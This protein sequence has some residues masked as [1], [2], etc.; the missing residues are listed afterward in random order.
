MLDWYYPID[1][2]SVIYKRLLPN[3]WKKKTIS[4]LT[5]N[6]KLLLF[7]FILLI[8]KPDLLF[9]NFIKKHISKRSSICNTVYSSVYT[10]MTYIENIQMN[11]QG[12]KI[13]EKKLLLPTKRRG[14]QG[15]KSGFLFII[16]YVN[17]IA[18]K[19]FFMCRHCYVFR[20]IIKTLRERG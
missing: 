10:S 6:I 18:K 16:K 5:S 3:P 14:Y 11:W 9:Q 8:V 15:C 12:K 2:Y 1:S 4:A 7:V 17:T 20:K 19:S 13:F